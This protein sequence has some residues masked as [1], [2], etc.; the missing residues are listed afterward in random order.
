[1]GHGKGEPSATSVALAG[2]EGGMGQGKGEP[3]A[4]SAVLLGGD[5]GM[6]HGNGDPSATTGLVMLGLRPFE[7]G[8]TIKAA[9]ISSPDR[10]AIFFMKE[11]SSPHTLRAGKASGE[12]GGKMF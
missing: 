11:P 4:T 8:S 6:G 10:Q 2:G 7:A 9:R 3:S 12:K 5:G 1:M